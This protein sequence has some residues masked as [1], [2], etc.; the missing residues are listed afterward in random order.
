MEWEIIDSSLKY[1]T[2]KYI[3]TIV[4]CWSGYGGNIRSISGALVTTYFGYENLEVLKNDMISKL[5]S[6]D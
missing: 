3:L 1:K 4:E 6:L 5:N 2:P